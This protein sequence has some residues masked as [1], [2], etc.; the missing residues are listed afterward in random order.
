MTVIDPPDGL[1]A[2][3]RKASSV[4]LSSHANPDGDAIGSELAMARILRSMGKSVTIWNQDPTP[5]LYRVLPGADEIHSGR[6][7]PD[8]FPESFELAIP[9]ECPTVDR[10]GLEE[11]LEQLPLLDI[12]HHLGNSRYGVAQWIDTEAPSAGEMLFRLAQALEVDVD[13]TTATLLYMTIVTDTGGFRFSNATAQAFASA[14]ELVRAG[15]DPETVSLWIYES[16]PVATLRLLSEMLD[17]LELHAAGRVAT[18]ELTAE[19]FAAAGARKEDSEG[20]IDY[21]RSIAGV[22]AVVLFRPLG[23]GS[24]KVSLRSR[25]DVDVAAIASRHRGGG[26]RNA[27]GC[28]LTDDG[29]DQRRDLVNEVVA[30]LD[31]RPGDPS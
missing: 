23:D 31:A 8:G 25:G 13:A 28:R 20:L 22:D 2:V 26:H 30:A 16:L 7:P 15:A 29:P 10:T 18:V 14:A 24:A 11:W 19:M 9:I 21:P 27:A 5:T 17:S 1:L 6:T 4:L 12:D 3:L